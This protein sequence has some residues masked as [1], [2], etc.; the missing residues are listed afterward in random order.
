MAILIG[1]S[2]NFMAQCESSTIQLLLKLPLGLLLQGRCG[3][4]GLD[5][6]PSAYNY[7]QCTNP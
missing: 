7:K 6:Y 1:Q 2:W 3:R 4:A 5:Y